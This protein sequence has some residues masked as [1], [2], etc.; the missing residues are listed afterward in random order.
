VFRIRSDPLLWA[1]GAVKIFTEP[2]PASDFRLVCYKMKVRS[3]VYIGIIFS[4]GHQ[5]HFFC[6]YENL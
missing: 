4:F 6:I 1:S 3:L 2:G 5:D